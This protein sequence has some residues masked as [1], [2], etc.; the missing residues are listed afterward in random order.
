ML[1]IALMGSEARGDA[2]PDSDIDLVRLLAEGVS[3]PPDSGSHLIC[4]RLVAVS[5]VTP[6]QAGHWCT[7]PE[8]AVQVVAGMRTA[9][10]LSDPTGAFATLQRQAAAFV[11]DAPMQH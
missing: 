10:P 4:G 11:W 5:D 7:R 6:E 3:A 9:V 2:G 1:A 8:R